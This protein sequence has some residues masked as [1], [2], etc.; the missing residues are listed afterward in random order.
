MAS[1]P[2]NLVIG[3][4]GA[5]GS[6]V[7]AALAATS[8]PLIT[9]SRQP[10]L[11]M[12]FDGPHRHLQCD[13]SGEAIARCVASLDQAALGRVVIC[14]GRLHDNPIWPEKRLEEL[15]SEAMQALFTSNAA[16]PLQ[17]L[18]ALLPAAKGKQPC[19][20]AALSARIGSIGD[21]GLGGWYSYR[22]S[23]A[24]LNMG[25]QTAA[26]EYGRRA[27]NA[28]LLAFHPGTTDSALS[29]PFQASVPPEKLFSPDFVAQQ[30]L[31]AMTEAESQP[32][33][34]ARF[35]D[36]QGKTIPW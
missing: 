10:A 3:A 6:A 33:G 21:N 19:V 4:S 14:N 1:P 16:V 8:H 23:K 28:R 11:A 34:A 9:V 17:W 31:R 29:A 13:Y 26:I 25:L 5:I 18:Q 22:M 24:A 35:V 27:K 15:T 2:T 36:W 7:A 32:P 30:L 12:Q 20:I